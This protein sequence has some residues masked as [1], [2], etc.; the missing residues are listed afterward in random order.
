MHA[1]RDEVRTQDLD[2]AHDREKV[3]PAAR[4]VFE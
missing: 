4:A 2:Q 3:Y 1:S